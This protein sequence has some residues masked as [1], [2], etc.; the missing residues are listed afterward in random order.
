VV[1][2]VVAAGFLVV[3]LRGGGGGGTNGI[4][5]SRVRSSIKLNSAARLS[6]A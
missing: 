4:H 3:G 2:A 6:G 5:A 1:V